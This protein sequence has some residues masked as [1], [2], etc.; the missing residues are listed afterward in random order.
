MSASRALLIII[1]QSPQYTSPSRFPSRTSME[2]DAF[3]QSLPLYTLQ[4]LQLGPHRELCASP[5]PSSPYPSRSSGKEPLP[6]SPNRA[7]AERDAPFLEPFCKYLSK[8]P[9]NGCPLVPQ[10]RETPFYRAFFYMF[11]NHLSL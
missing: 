1:F 3:L 4:A 9:V 2:R 6:G 5:E 10:Q 8:F 11:P 7:P